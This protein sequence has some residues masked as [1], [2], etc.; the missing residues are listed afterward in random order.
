MLN[1]PG[2]MHDSKMTPWGDIYE[3][4]AR[5]PSPFLLVADEAFDTH[6]ILK[7]KLVKSKQQRQECHQTS[8]DSIEVSLKN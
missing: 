4:I 8:V 6:G 2:S 3:H 5:L 1:N 7:D